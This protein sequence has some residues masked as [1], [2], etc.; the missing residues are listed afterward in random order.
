MSNQPNEAGSLKAIV[1][2]FLVL[3]DEILHAFD[4]I[5]FIGNAE[6]K[7]RFCQWVHQLEDTNA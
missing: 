1:I 4:D 2:A 7:F 5:P 3:V 6:W